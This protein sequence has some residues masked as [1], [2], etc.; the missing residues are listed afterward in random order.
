MRLRAVAIVHPSE[1]WSHPPRWWRDAWWQSVS[2]WHASRW[3][4]SHGGDPPSGGTLLLVVAS[5]GCS[6]PV[7]GCLGWRHSRVA[8]LPCSGTCALRRPSLGW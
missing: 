1:W 4:A 5:H 7:G 8:P 3:H 6:H 2:C